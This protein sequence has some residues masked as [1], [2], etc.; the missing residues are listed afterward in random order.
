MKIL[1]TG[2]QRSGTTLLRNLFSL[3]PEIKH[4]F[5]E[6]CILQHFKTKEQMRK[7][8]ELPDYQ[9]LNKR[10]RRGKYRTAIKAKI[11]FDLVADNWGEKVPYYGLVFR[12]GYNGPMK[13]YCKLWNDFFYPDCKIIHIIRHPLDVGL[14]TR[15]RGYSRGVTK[16]IRQYKKAVPTVIKMFDDFPNVITIK[17]EGLVMNPKESLKFLFDECSLTS[18][19]RVIDNIMN[20]DV[21]WFGFINPDRAFNFRKQRINIPKHKLGPTIEFLNTKIPGIKYNLKRKVKNDKK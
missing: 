10:N 13:E 5:H 17:Y 16:P 12:K 8:K 9:T 15:K 2:F 1:I 14:S 21:Y 7:I 19:E 11:D 4:V 18:S 3:H 6:Q 20:S